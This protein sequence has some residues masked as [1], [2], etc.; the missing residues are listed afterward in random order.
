MSP[1]TEITLE[2]LPQLLQDDNKVKLAGVDVDDS[3]EQVRFAMLAAEVLM[4][5]LAL[6]RGKDGMYV[7]WVDTIRTREIISSWLAR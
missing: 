6:G 1:Q 2:S 7:V 4:A 3:V 5:Q